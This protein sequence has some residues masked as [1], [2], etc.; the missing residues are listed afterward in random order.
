MSSILSYLFYQSSDWGVSLSLRFVLDQV[1]GPSG[2]PVSISFYVFTGILLIGSLLILLS[3]FGTLR[4][5]RIEKLL[6]FFT[7]SLTVLAGGFYTILLLMGQKSI[8]ELLV[9]G[10]VILFTSVLIGIGTRVI[11]AD[12]GLE[13]EDIKTS[14]QIKDI[15]ILKEKVPL[16]CALTLLLLLLTSA[17]FH[18]W[19][20]LWVAPFAFLSTP[21]ISW[22]FMILSGPLHFLV[23][24]PW[25][26]GSYF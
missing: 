16:I 14:V 2:L 20:L 13:K 21:R 17:Q 22:T 25:D 12:D 7:V 23:Y 18:P 15:S 11:L 5:N 24:P 19:Y 10:T 26:M 8:V 6:L 3:G 1:L 9:G 4:R